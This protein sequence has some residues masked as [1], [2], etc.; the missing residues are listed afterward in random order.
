MRL[1]LMPCPHCHS[2]GALIRLG[3]TYGFDETSDPPPGLLGAPEPKPG[4]ASEA[5]RGGEEVCGRMVRDQLQG[6]RP[7]AF[8]SRQRLDANGNGQPDGGSPHGNR[9][10]ARPRHAKPRHEAGAFLHALVEG[11][12]IDVDVRGGAG[13]G[14]DEQPRGTNAASGGSVAQA[15][16]RLQ[17]RRRMPIRGAD[18]DRRNFG[19]PQKLSVL[20]RLLQQ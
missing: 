5:R 6:V 16:L 4:K 18:L 10:P 9:R 1:N 3:F 12:A 15:K 2:V 8:V 11:A 17:Q 7:M 20:A 19:F 13:R 14:T